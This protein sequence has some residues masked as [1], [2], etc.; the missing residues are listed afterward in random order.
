MDSDKRRVHVVTYGCQMNSHDSDRM[1]ELLEPLGFEG[2]SDKLSADLVILNTCSVREK[3]D[4]KLFSELGRLREWREEDPS[5]ILAVGGCVAQ[6]MGNDLLQRCRHLDLVFGTDQL[7]EL[8][9]MVSRISAH[10]VR[11]AATEWRKA[12]E[13]D[14]LPIRPQ[15]RMEGT[16]AFVK[17][18]KGCNK[19]CTYCIVPYVKG[20]ELY[21]PSKA[22]IDEVRLLVERHGVREVTLL[23]QTVTSYNLKNG[24]SGEPRFAELLLR[25][26]EIEGLH[27]VRFM[28]GYPKDVHDDLLEAFRIQ[29]KIQP[30]IHMPVQSGSD[31]ILRLMNRGY[32]RDTYLEKMA[33]LRA[34]RPGLSLTSDLIV[35]FPG[36]TEDDFLQTISLMEEV[37]YDSV[38]SFAYSER[39]GTRAVS[40]ADSVPQA[41][42]RKRLVHLNAVQD[43]ITRALLRECVG[44]TQEVLVL[45][46]SARDPEM[47]RGRTPE[48]RMINF[49]GKAQVGDLVQVEVQEAGHHTLRGAQ[50]VINAA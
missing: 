13:F 14:F 23:G 5:R 50:V 29:H 46:P 39:P 33:A 32:R 12:D 17:I 45:G 31:R 36:E 10:R 6:G 44:R 38:F 4:Q 3:A 48:H 16:H 43:R 25:V 18:M 22:I 27:R 28:T 21:R 2:T 49:V 47:L 9:D 41:E 34:A 1:L 40:F 11:V 42:R 30:Y 24:K 26:A 19:F 15:R 37:R 8:P 35:G 7:A 20:R